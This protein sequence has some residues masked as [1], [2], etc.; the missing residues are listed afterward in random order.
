MKAISGLNWLKQICRMDKQALALVGRGLSLL[1]AFS[2]LTLLEGLSV[3]YIF[4]FML[5]FL[6]FLCYT[7]PG[8]CKYSS[9][10][11]KI[12]FSWLFYTNYL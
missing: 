2:F 1:R 5:H 10:E 3:G 9:I 6:I 11:H 7:L 12:A 8:F 4:H